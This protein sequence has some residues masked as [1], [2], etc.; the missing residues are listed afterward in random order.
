MT[1]DESEEPTII[2]VPEIEVERIETEE[3]TPVRPSTNH[4][5][6]KEDDDN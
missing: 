4:H 5:E 2:V 1:E 6:C 3:I